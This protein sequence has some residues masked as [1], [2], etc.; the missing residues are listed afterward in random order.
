MIYTANY[1]HQSSA[2]L[3]RRRWDEQVYEMRNSVFF[4]L[5]K[6]WEKFVYTNKSAN[7]TDKTDQYHF[8]NILPP[9]WSSIVNASL[10]FISVHYK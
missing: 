2:L 3:H 6:Q 7:S 5:V 4:C 10:I 9:G 1:R 8:L